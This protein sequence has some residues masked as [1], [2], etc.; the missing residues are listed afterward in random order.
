MPL[1]IKKP[2][3]YISAL[4]QESKEPLHIGLSFGGTIT[5]AQASELVDLARAI[6]QSK[7]DIKFFWIRFNE[8][9]DSVFSAFN[10]FGRELVGASTISSFALE[11]NVGFEEVQCIRDFL[12]LNDTIR[13]IKFLRTNLC[14]SSF[15][16]IRPFFE[17]NGSLRVLDVSSNFLVGDE[18]IKDVLDAIH[19]GCARLEVLNITE[20]C[21]DGDAISSNGI[22]VR[23]AEFISS[24]VSKTPTLTSLKLC[25]RELNDEG[26]GS[27]AVVLSKK[28]CCVS[29][30]DIGGRFGDSGIKIL[31]EALKINRSMKT[32]T[33]SHCQNLTD[34]GGQVMLSAVDGSESWESATCSNNVL[35]S[36][37]ISERSNATMNKD[38]VIKLQSL[39]DVDPQRTLQSKV[40]RYM[41]NHMGELSNVGLKAKHI[42]RVIC[43]VNKRGGLD[44][45]YRVLQNCNMQDV[46]YNRTPN[47]ARMEQ[48]EQENKV[49][50]ELLASERESNASLRQE[51]RYLRERTRCCWVP[52]MKALELWKVLV[53]MLREL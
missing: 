17:R 33:I 9:D 40:W 13:G 10:S 22:S 11:D 32:I 14:H 48:I 41:D 36:V 12:I 39:A 52:I 31:A 4:K 47:R 15:S 23:G 42:P 1:I 6:R 49:L 29:R 25:L 34:V 16:S 21:I 20:N 37:Y 46:V 38:L 18:T 53:D 19:Q 35:R 7:R 51:N 2:S 44:G 30:L 28:A 26:V 3:V 24:F 5:D 50:K 43:F 8:G 45:M 27:L